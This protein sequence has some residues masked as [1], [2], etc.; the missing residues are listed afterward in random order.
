MFRVAFSRSALKLQS[1]G[2][3]VHGTNLRNTD[4]GLTTMK[5]VSVPAGHSPLCLVI[6]LLLRSSAL[7]AL[8]KHA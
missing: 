7:F 5:R 6:L 2:V 1:L 3:I 8:S 4:H